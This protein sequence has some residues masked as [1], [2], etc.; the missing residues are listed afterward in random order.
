V[1]LGVRPVAER[2]APCLAAPVPL[3]SVTARSR[4]LLALGNCF[5]DVSASVSLFRSEPVVSSTQQAEI[6]RAGAAALAARDL[7]V[8][9]EKG[10]RVTAEAI[11]RDER[12]APS[13]ASD[14]F[15]AG[16]ARYVGGSGAPRLSR[17]GR[18]ALLSFRE[19]C[20]Q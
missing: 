15:A 3:P 16:R 10:R 13:V 9:L 20:E 6:F 11:G 14:D 4:E 8:E 1:T 17:C 5:C 18:R 7:V 2:R 19:L 12:A